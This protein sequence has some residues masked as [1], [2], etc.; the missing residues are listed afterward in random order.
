MFTLLPLLDTSVVRTFNF[1][2]GVGFWVLNWGAR[3]QLST[4]MKR[5][6]NIIL[7]F[8]GQSHGGSRFNI[9]NLFFWF[10]FDVMLINRFVNTRW[11]FSIAGLSHCLMMEQIKERCAWMGLT[12]VLKRLYSIW[13]SLKDLCSNQTSLLAFATWGVACSEKLKLREYLWT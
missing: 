7:A 3:M 8:A 13:F 6:M 2:K 12:W 4:L 10:R 11:M 5:L 1:S 9:L